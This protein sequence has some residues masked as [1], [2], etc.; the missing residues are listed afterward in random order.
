MRLPRTRRKPHRPRD[1]EVVSRLMRAVRSRD[2]LAERKLRKALS[3]IGARYRLQVA[4]LPGRPDIVFVRARVVVFVDGDFWHG[5]IFLEQGLRGLRL[6]LRTE[7]REWWINKIVRN[8]ERDALN[9][10]ALEGLDFAVVRIWEKDLL[11]NAPRIASHI[12]RMVRTR[13]IRFSNS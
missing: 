5:R 1:K 8:V 9:T 13:S 6:S 12:G 7:R 2:N 3:E 10:A 4:W 11:R